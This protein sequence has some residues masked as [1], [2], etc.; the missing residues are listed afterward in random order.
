[1]VEELRGLGIETMITHWPFMSIDSVWRSEYEAA[2][3]LAINRKLRNVRCDKIEFSWFTACLLFAGT[4][5][6][7]DLF[8]EY[9]QNGSLIMPYTDAARNLTFNKWVAG[10]GVHGVRAVWLDE[11]EPDRASY[12]YGS[13]TCKCRD[14]LQR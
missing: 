1:M 6:E 5:G 11:T 14:G 7:A 12:S 9:L 13:W 3:A 10:Y 8:R 2:G 4:S